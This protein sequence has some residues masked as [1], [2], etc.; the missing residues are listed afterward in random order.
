MKGPGQLKHFVFA[1]L[2]AGMAYV[3]LY[4]VIEA[5]RLKSG[6]WEVTFTNYV[7]GTPALVVKQD[8]AC[9]SSR[10]ILFP[11]QTAPAGAAGET[12]IFRDA[13]P[14]PF[15]LPYGRCIFLDTTFL[16]GTVVFELFGHTV[17][18]MPRALILDRQDYE[19]RSGFTSVKAVAR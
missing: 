13:K 7:D 16:P 10:L 19:W 15:P 4:N 17:E 5:S 8:R 18:L 12:L 11:G 6:P 1:F 14:V 9:P 3:L 2:L